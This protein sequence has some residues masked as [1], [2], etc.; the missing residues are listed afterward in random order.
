M[1]D[2][3]VFYKK[4]VEEKI[5][6]QM[7]AVDIS[8][9][10]VLTYI[11]RRS[12]KTFGLGTGALVKLDD[13]SDSELFQLAHELMHVNI[14]QEVQSQKMKESAKNIKYEKLH[15]H[16]TTQTQVMACLGRESW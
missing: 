4:I 10:E 14:V 15:G 2:H 5:K 11:A 16:K 7:Q 6:E 8:E 13:F 1:Q 9:A 12:E 3:K